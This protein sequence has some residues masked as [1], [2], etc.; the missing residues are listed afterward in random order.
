MGQIFN[1]LGFMFNIGL[2][3]SAAS[4]YIIKELIDK[5]KKFIK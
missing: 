2:V 5:N 4:Y 3:C 1:H